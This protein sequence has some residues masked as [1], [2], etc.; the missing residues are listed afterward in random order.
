MPVIEMQMKT[1]GQCQQ[2]IIVSVKSKC[3][4]YLSKGAIA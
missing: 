2:R 4:E 1:N 3:V